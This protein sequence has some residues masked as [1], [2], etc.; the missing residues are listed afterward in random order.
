MF[1]CYFDDA[2]NKQDGFTAVAGYISTLERWRSFAE[3]WALMLAVFRVP[4]YS[5]KHLSHFKSHYKKWT[6]EIK[7]AFQ[8]EACRVIAKNTLYQFG[9]V[10]RHDLFEKANKDY[11]L[12]EHV[13]NPYALAGF[14]CVYKAM[15]WAVKQEPKESIEFIFDDGTEKRGNLVKLMKA[16][17]YSEPIFRS[18]VSRGGLRAVTQLQAA[19]FLAYEFRKVTIEDPYETRPIE[20]HRISL[21][22]LIWVKSEWSQYTEAD[23][24]QT[25]ENHPKIKRRT[26]IQESPC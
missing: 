6:P 16:E 10:V 7:N 11:T 8:S 2:G 19:D 9:A 12:Q 18:P 5:M 26:P 15:L 4:E 1:T 20:E 21:R 13:G 22:K 17:G 14:T 3:D 24:V 25:C 23:L